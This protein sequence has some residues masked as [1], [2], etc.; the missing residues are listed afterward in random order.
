VLAVLAGRAAIASVARTRGAW[1]VGGV[2]VL[3]GVAALWWVVAAHANALRPI[4]VLPHYSAFSLAA[5]SFGQSTGWVHQMVGVF[6]W[7]DTPVPFFTEIVLYAAVGFVLVL[8]ISV[9]TLRPVLALLLLVAA[10]VVIP[11]AILQHD[12][13]Q[14]GFFWQGRYTLPLA[15]GLPIVAAS[16]IEGTD[17]LAR[18]RLRISVLLSVLLGAASF[19][20]FFTSE[21]RYAS[22]LPGPIGLGHSVWRPPFG[23]GVMAL[24]GLLGEVLLVAMVI[25]L[26]STRSSDAPDTSANSPVENGPSRP[27]AV[28]AEPA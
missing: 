4:G 6:G 17:V 26:V 5:N 27:I 9:A 3:S 18:F 23:N 24:W 2:I 12:A 28:G 25:A 11:V 16:L 10:V 20:A 14:L 7:L 22:G 19:A 21:R 13:H 15:V 1:I 8:A